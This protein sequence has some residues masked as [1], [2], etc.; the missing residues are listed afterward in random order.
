MFTFYFG[1]SSLK[2]L[3]ACNQNSD[4]E[5]KLYTQIQSEKIDIGIENK[6]QVN[7]DEDIEANVCRTKS[8]KS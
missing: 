2:T 3:I 6:F 5:K 1:K 7:L 4:H 8:L